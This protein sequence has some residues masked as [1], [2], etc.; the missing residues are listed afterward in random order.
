[1]VSSQVHGKQKGIIYFAGD[2]SISGRDKV[3]KDREISAAGHSGE[4]KGNPDFHA[5]LWLHK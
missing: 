2:Y 4:R 1:M 3:I 5:A